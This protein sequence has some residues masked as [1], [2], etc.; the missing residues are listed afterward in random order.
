MSLVALALCLSACGTTVP[1]IVRSP[2]RAPP[3]L[4]SVAADKNDKTGQEGVWL[5]WGDYTG[6]LEF[7]EHTRNVKKAGW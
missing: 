1:E 3:L 6:T 7:F 2:L 4:K 5:D